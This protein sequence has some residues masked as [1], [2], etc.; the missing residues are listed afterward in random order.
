MIYF[1]GCTSDDELNFPVMQIALGRFC[2]CC[3]EH[4]EVIF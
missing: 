1:L 2:A 4:L 3:T